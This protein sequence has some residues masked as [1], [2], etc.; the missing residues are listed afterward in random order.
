VSPMRLNAREGDFIETI[1]GMLLDVKGLVHPPKHVVAF[2]R[3]FPSFN[4]NRSRQGV[5]YKKVYSLGKRYE[6]LKERFPQYLVHDPVFDEILCEVPVKDLTRHYQPIKTLKQL[7]LSDELDKVQEQVLG[8]S[9]LIR[10]SANIGWD[11]LGVSGSVM[12]GLHTLTSDIDL[13]I[14]GVENCLRVHS[15]LETMLK[16]EEASV[17]PYTRGELKALFEF[18][19][20]DTE[21][22]YDDFVKSESRKVF[23]GKFENRDYFL[24]LLKDYDEVDEVYG[25][26]RYRNVGT[27]RIRALITCDSESVFTPCRYLVDE[28]EFLEG[29]KVDGLLEVVS[30][31]GRFCEQAKKGEYVLAQGKVEQV[32]KSEG[33]SHYRLL[34]GNKPSDQMVLI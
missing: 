34:L 2:P 15:A 26:I 11:K 13:V 20:K 25:S 27:S 8:L 10:D 33:E 30:F 7:R 31:R 9:R 22:S 19:S 23:Q 5:T 18:R 3:Y 32:L 6:L 14:Y 17:K 24:R 1:H 29:V 16:D 12:V 4:G 28:V 21:M